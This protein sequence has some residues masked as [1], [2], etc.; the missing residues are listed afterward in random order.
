M[1]DVTNKL[2]L[3][4]LSMFF[5][6]LSGADHLVTKLTDKITSSC[7]HKLILAYMP[8]IMVCL[9]VR[10]QNKSSSAVIHNT[11]SLVIIFL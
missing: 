11:F 5:F 4:R 6:L 1:Y 3:T 8:L 2:I 7:S 10:K 9:E